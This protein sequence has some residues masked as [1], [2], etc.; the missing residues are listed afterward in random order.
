MSKQSDDTSIY[1]K[2]QEQQQSRSQIS[3]PLTTSTPPTA[4]SSSHPF[5]AT[6]TEFAH[7]LAHHDKD[8]AE[9]YQETF[10]Y[11]LSPLES[12]FS[13]KQTQD[14]PTSMGPLAG[15]YDIPT[16]GSFP[17]SSSSRVPFPMSD[18][19]NITTGPPVG[20]LYPHFVEGSS[21]STSKFQPLVATGQYESL[22]QEFQSSYST[23]SLLESGG[24][25]SSSP[26]LQG[27]LFHPTKTEPCSRDITS[28]TSSPDLS[29]TSTRLHRHLSGDLQPYKSVGRPRRG[30]R[31]ESLEALK[32]E[33][34]KKKHNTPTLFKYFFFLGLKVQITEQPRPKALRF[35]Y[36]CEGRSAGSIP[37]VHST[38]TRKT[39]PTIRV[40]N[41]KG[42]AL[43]V[44]SCVTVTEPY[45]PHPHNLVGKEGCEDGICSVLIDNA[46]M[47]CSFSNLGIQCVKKRDIESSLAKRA[48]KMID[49][50]HTRT[51]ENPQSI[52]LNSIRLCFQVYLL[53]RRSG[54]RYPL[55]PIVSEPIYDKKDIKVRFFEMKE[56]QVEWEA[57]G[58]FQSSDVHKQVAISFKTPRYKD[59]EVTQTVKVSLQLFRP[60][61]KSVSETVPFEYY[62]INK[63][64]DYVE[65]RILHITHPAS[66]EVLTSDS[67]AESMQEVSD[68]SDLT[69]YS[70]AGTTSKSVKRFK[71][72]SSPSKKGSTSCRSKSQD[73]PA[74]SGQS[75]SSGY[76]VS[77]GLL[78]TFTE[79]YSQERGSTSYEQSYCPQIEDLGE[80]SYDVKTLQMTKESTSVSYSSSVETSSIL[81]SSLLPIG[82]TATFASSSSGIPTT[83]GDVEAREGRLQYHNLDIGELSFSLE[84]EELV[85]EESLSP[86]SESIKRLKHDI[87]TLNKLSN[88]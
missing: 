67:P 26:L 55:Q 51:S 87:E 25:S 66:K 86:N 1:Q 37:G 61:D 72:S 12:K 27:P 17:L 47:E 79:S 59:L 41:S 4:S 6:E 64:Y 32:T 38:P 65:D 45:K 29:E 70:S 43:V 54:D 63:D 85:K 83:E 82:P 10:Q 88:L 84:K 74:D 16:V 2:F 52:D 3:V 73:P 75:W 81:T 49:P 22:A 62:P 23:Q 60:S 76:K 48:A 53:D 30:R 8:I 14:V 15:C 50:Y 58:D 24:S 46:M 33:T 7:S 35:R 69:D 20:Q 56:N 39:F 11:D 28:S 13:G 77:E 42:P 31:K 71:S 57:F 34:F 5:V 36:I 80:P 18:I 68:E 44:V 40:V 78:Q 19:E 9:L 21:P